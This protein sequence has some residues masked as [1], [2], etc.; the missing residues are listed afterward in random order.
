MIGAEKRKAIEAKYDM[1]VERLMYKFYQ[2]HEMSAGEIAD[3]LDGVGDFRVHRNTVKYWLRQS[4]IEMRTRQLTDVQRVLMLA[5]FDSGVGDGGIARRL[6]CGKSTVRRYR[7]DI[8][9]EH[10][11]SDFDSWISSDDY[12]LLVEI[13]DD[14]FGK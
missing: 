5:Y 11:P 4:G 6:K 8:E 3:E 1:P 10:E 7:R 2:E 9:A 14:T 12:K 13:V